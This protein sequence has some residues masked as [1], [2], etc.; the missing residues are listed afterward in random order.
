MHSHSIFDHMLKF[1]ELEL[2]KPE[3]HG[4]APLLCAAYYNNAHALKSLLSKEEVS[5]N[6]AMPNGKTSLMVAAY[7]G[8]EEIVALLLKAGC[9]VNMVMTRERVAGGLEG[10]ITALMIA[11]NGGHRRIVTSLLMAG[12][13]KNIITTL[14]RSAES[15][16]STRGHIGVAEIISGYRH[17]EDF[18]EIDDGTMALLGDVVPQSDVEVFQAAAALSRAADREGV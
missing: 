12:A 9:E 11:A 7:D 14:G 17:E 2:N 6:E 18:T 13:D 16:A 15:I 10:N 4:E 3:S 1:R 8:R 5:P